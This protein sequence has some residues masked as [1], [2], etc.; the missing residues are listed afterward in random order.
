MI[1]LSQLPE[2]LRDK[3]EIEPNS[4]CWLWTGN[5]DSRGYSRASVCNR[6]IQVHALVY[7]MFVGAAPVIH[8]IC[9]TKFCINPSHLQAVTRASHAKLHGNQYVNRTHCQRGHEYAVTAFSVRRGIWRCCSACQKIRDK[10]KSPNS[11]I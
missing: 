1:A 2:R 9:R 11:T 3:I 10:R 6:S 7:E 4:G 8:H 5:L